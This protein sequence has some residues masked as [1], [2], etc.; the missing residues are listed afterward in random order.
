MIVLVAIVTAVLEEVIGSEEF[1][2]EFIVHVSLFM[3][4]ELLH[5]DMLRGVCAE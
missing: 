2:N 5:K 4:K 1:R 3:Q